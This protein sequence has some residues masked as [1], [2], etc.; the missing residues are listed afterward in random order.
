MEKRRKGGRSSSWDV[1]VKVMNQ[2]QSHQVGSAGHVVHG[3]T[4]ACSDYGVAMPESR[5]FEAIRSAV[6]WPFCSLISL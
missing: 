6:T 1:V 5:G 3:M 4:R 2:V